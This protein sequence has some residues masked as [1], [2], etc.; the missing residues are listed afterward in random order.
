MNKVLIVGNGF[1]LAHGLLTGYGNFLDIMK[2]WTPIYDMLKKVNKGG[3]YP[4]DYV[5]E[6]YV[7]NAADIN[8][9]NLSELDR[10]IRN[11]S[12]ISYYKKCEAEIDGWIDFER[13]I[14]P[15]IDLFEKVFRQTKY[16]TLTHGNTDTEVLM[17]RMLFDI[18]EINIAKL[19]EKYF[20]VDSKNI[21]L[22]SPYVSI[23]YGILKK[24]IMKSLREEFDEFI[25]A[26]EIYLLEFVYRVEHTEVLEQ[27][28]NINADYVVSFNYTRT[29]D[30]YGI[31]HSK[32][33]HIHGSIRHDFKYKNNM[34][35]GVNE[36]K[37]QNI[38]FIYF[39]KYFQRIQKATG[40]K[41][42]EFVDRYHV[43]SCG[44]HIKDKYTLHIYGHS[45]DETDEDILRYVI[46]N[47]DESGKLDLKPEKVIIYYYDD[48]DYEQKVVNLIKLYGRPIVEE[49]MEKDKFFFI[50]TDATKCSI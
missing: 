43:D 34:V 22:K 21:S 5:F 48:S 36:Q 47:T 37:D 10:I 18:G 8:M 20:K 40:I 1:D 30:L 39:V 23:Q 7:S 17:S 42:K 6:K 12:W 38:D 2:N 44:Q 9:D 14:Y 41:Y 19:W 33:H 15:V 11:N 25:K 31:L 3:S 13:E 35:M 32:T 45:L 29:E 50:P 4:K 46:G 16:E 26:F 24:Q 28:K 49:Y 27:I